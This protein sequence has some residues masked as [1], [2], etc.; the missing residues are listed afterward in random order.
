MRRVVPHLPVRRRL[1]E[2]SPALRRFQ[3][4]MIKALRHF[5]VMLVVVERAYVV[6]S[7]VFAAETTRKENRTIEHGLAP[8]AVG[9]RSFAALDDTRGKVCGVLGLRVGSLEV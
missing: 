6:W 7:D 3:R 9:R 5:V 4:D 1:R 2:T 8:R